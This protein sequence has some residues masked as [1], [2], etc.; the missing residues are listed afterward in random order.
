MHG[1][2]TRAKG[3]SNH[4]VSP[5]TRRH[6]MAV[7]GPFRSRRRGA[8]LRA[9]L[10]HTGPRH[11]NEARR[12]DRRRVCS[13]PRSRRR[14]VHGRRA[15]RQ[16]DDLKLTRRVP[17]AAQ[18]TRVRRRH[19]GRIIQ[20]TATRVDANR[21]AGGRQVVR[22]AP[23][24]ELDLLEQPLVLSSIRRRPQ[25]PIVEG[26]VPRDLHPANRLHTPRGKQSPAS[27]TIPEH[28]PTQAH[29]ACRE[30]R[31]PV[32]QYRGPEARGPKTRPA[33]TAHR[34]GCST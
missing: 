30:R 21:I 25:R 33:G 31:Q 3:Y 10:T 8:G 29:P 18:P 23:M 13:W 20:A 5:A 6:L 19:M 14:S 16:R 12:T 4:A 24:N 1:R 2:T 11:R 7:L 15:V 17:P 32:P 26:L 9:P 22:G 34:W 28:F 27:R